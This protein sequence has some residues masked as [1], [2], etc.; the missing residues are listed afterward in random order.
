MG[1]LDKLNSFIQAATSK[2]SPLADPTERAYYEIVFNVLRVIHVADYLAIKRYVDFTLGQPCNEEVLQSAL[3]YIRSSARDDGSVRYE[4]YQDHDLY[5]SK[6]QELCEIRSEI[7]KR[8]RLAELAPR[9]MEILGI[10]FAEEIENIK[11]E[12]NKAL[13]I[14]L[15]TAS[16]VFLNQALGKIKADLKCRDELLYLA[17]KQSFLE[18]NDVVR[19]AMQKHYMN[20]LERRAKNKNDDIPT[21]IYFSAMA[22]R[23]AHYEKCSAKENEYKPFPV[24]ECGKYIKA[25]EF[26]ATQP[27]DE[28]PT[29]LGSYVQKF[30]EASVFFDSTT[31]TIFDL[32]KFWDICTKDDY[33]M[34]TLCYLGWSTIKKQCA[35][36]ATT[37]DEMANEMYRFAQLIQ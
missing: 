33:F 5:T 21:V 24:N 6:P 1:F 23:A 30:R 14:P 8:V 18:E 37:I 3:K 29:L 36:E 2:Q 22:F 12:I 10:C 25:S 31:Y 11:S 26:F 17:F 32:R 7:V 4:N 34:D 15:E 13:D 35:S 19:L 27:F 9:K 20:V 28:Y 16:K